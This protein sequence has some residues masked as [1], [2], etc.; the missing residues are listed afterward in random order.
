M[1]KR[2]PTPT[3]VEKQRGAQRQAAGD[4]HRRAIQ[5]THTTPHICTARPPDARSPAHNPAHH[6]N[7]IFT[8]AR[9]PANANRTLS[10][11]NL[12]ES[13]TPLG[14]ILATPNEVIACC[15]ACSSAYAPRRAACSHACNARLPAHANRTLSDRNLRESPTP[16]GFILAAPNEV[17]ACCSACASAYAPLHVARSP[18]CNARS[19]AHAHRSIGDRNTTESTALLSPLKELRKCDSDCAHPPCHF[20]RPQAC[21]D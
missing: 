11:R 7:G 6:Y 15:S 16:L 20:P 5:C 4:E 12:R 8:S 3:H 18:A 1:N 10:D 21:P 13:P 17:T 14:F 19:T 2:T 9:S